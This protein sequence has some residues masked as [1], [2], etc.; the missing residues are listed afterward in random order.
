MVFKNSVG[1]SE[2]QIKEIGPK[3]GCM[4][5]THSLFPIGQQLRHQEA[6]QN[7]QTVRHK[8]YCIFQ[9][10]EIQIDLTIPLVK[11]I[12]KDTYALKMFAFYGKLPPP[13]VL[14]GRPPRKMA[15]FL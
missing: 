1:D 11:H 2:L 4:L 14:T 15:F 7:L 10:H 13:I 5:P 12:R 8:K 9:H 6:R 3:K